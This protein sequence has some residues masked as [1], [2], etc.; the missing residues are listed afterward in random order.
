MTIIQDIKLNGDFR[1]GREMMKSARRDMSREITKLER[2]IKKAESY[3][4]KERKLLKEIKKE[5][6]FYSV[7]KTIP[8]TYKGITVN[9]LLLQ[10]FFK[11]LKGFTVSIKAEDNTLILNYMKQGSNKGKLDLYDISKYFEGYPDIPAIEV[12]GIE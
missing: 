2:E 11:K 6:P 1:E 8:A 5:L 7:S 4:G 10:R 3:A 9:G 12:E